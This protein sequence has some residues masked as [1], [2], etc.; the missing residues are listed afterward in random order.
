M[1]IGQGEAQV[2]AK[3]ILVHDLARQRALDAVRSAPGGF[4]VLVKEPTRNSSQNARM[5]AMLEEVSRQVEWYG[6]RLSSED[7]KHVFSASLK[8]LTVVPNL[9]GSGFVALGVS[10]SRMSKAEM[11]DLIELMFA[12]GAERG[13]RWSEPEA[14]AA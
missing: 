10:T 5:W 11:S 3:F 4:E 14:R 1:R 2:T 6:K 13:V 12:F 7:W 9:D 8:K